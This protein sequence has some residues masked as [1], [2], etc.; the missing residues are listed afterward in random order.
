M[1]TMDKDNSID[2]VRG[3]GKGRGSGGPSHQRNRNWGHEEVMALIS[4]K[5]KEQIALK[6]I[7]DP[8]PTWFLQSLH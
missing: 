2:N 1:D 8:Q 5:P 6:Q 7:I 3:K 4:W